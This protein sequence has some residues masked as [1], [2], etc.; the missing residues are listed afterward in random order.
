M[1][2]WQVYR[3][4]QITARKVIGF[5]LCESTACETEIKPLLGAGASESSQPT[6]LMRTCSVLDT[7]RSLPPLQHVTLPERMYV[8]RKPISS[9]PYFFHG[10]S[11]QQ[12]T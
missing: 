8:L 3:S 11:I 7:G 9:F 1:T 5:Q 12:A 6:D 10:I 2:L 4:L